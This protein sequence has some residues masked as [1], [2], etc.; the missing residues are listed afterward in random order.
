MAQGLVRARHRWRRSTGSAPQTPPRRYRP[1]SSPRAAAVQQS[2]GRTARS[3][4]RIQE[5]IDAWLAHITVSVSR[6][7]ARSAQRSISTRPHQLAQ[8]PQVDHGDLVQCCRSDLAPC[9]APHTRQNIALVG[10]CRAADVVRLPH[11]CSGAS[12]LG[13]SQGI[14]G[15]LRSIARTAF[16]SASSK[17]D[18]SRHDLAGRHHLGAQSVRL[19]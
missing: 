12:I 13:M 8:E 17:R 4:V 2:S 11:P 7:R 10:A 5:A 3:I 16:I 9:A 15:S 6:P 1:P 18:P 19:A 14:L